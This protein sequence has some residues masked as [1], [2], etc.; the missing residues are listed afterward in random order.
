MN[1]QTQDLKE[2][3]LRTDEEFSQLVAKHH[4]LEDRLH[5]LTAKHYLSEPEQVE[6][7]NLKKRKLQLKDRMEDILRRHR[8]QS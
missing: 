2:V 5:Q 6:E 1:A 8:Q 7:T 3:L 4:A